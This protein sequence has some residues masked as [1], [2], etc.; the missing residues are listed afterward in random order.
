M[1]GTHLGE[2]EELLLLVLAGMAPE[3]S[4]SI[5]LVAALH[6]KAGRAV[7]GPVVHATLARLE[8]KGFVKSELGGATAE[9]GGRR[10]RYYQLT[11]GGYQVLSHAK[12]QRNG[13]WNIIPEKPWE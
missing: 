1:K 5:A 2:F 7:A 12:Q 10:K 9:R 8:T 3:E 6:E 13:L 11:Y 4:Y